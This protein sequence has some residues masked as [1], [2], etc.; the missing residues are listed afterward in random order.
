MSPCRRSSG[1]TQRKGRPAPVQHDA[2]AGVPVD[3]R[4]FVG[5]SA[6]CRRCLHGEPRGKGATRL[7]PA[8]AASDQRGGRERT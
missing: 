5:G 1:E 4:A 8:G 2:F 3:D 6:H 7:V